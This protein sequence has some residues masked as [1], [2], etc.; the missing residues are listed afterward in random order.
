[1][2]LSLV[3][4]THQR[5]AML[6]TSIRRALSLLPPDTELIVVDNA[7]TDGTAD[8]VRRTYPKATLI[9][10]PTNEGMPARNH[11]LRAATRNVVLLMDDDAW[12]IAW[13]DDAVRRFDQEPYLAALVARV[14]LPN[15]SE[16]SPAMPGVPMGGASLVRRSAVLDVGGFP[17][18]FR[19]QAEE[20]DLAF[21]LAARGLLIERDP[22]IVLHH[23]KTPGGR[24]SAE[25]LRL[26][27]VHNLIIVE[28]HLPHRARSAYRRDW[29][30]RYARLLLRR[31]ANSHDAV[32]LLRDSLRE[33]HRRCNNARRAPTPLS[34]AAFERLFAWNLAADAVDAWSR[35]YGVRRAILVGLGKN[36]FASWRAA[37]R[38]GL[39]TPVLLD[40]RPAFTGTT[41]R[42]AS[43]IPPMLWRPEPG[44]GYVIAESSPARSQACLDDVG[45]GPIPT[46]NPYST[47]EK[48]A[49]AHAWA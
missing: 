8:A 34:P 17:A 20:Y 46:L 39:A 40:G 31:C 7:S 42:G 44:D 4:I 37:Q 2:S 26:D 11:G 27:L 13:N 30:R 25:V 18:D 41:Y 49:E 33:A 28:R 9:E 35:Q 14:V 47:C 29:L 21:R 10:R 43:V 5:R 3:I 45:H 1:M 38:A 15:G 36:A 12:P 32:E 23:D 24:P 19:R 22:R 48:H 6:L 16:E